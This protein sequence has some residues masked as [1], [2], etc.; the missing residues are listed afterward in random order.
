VLYRHLLLAGLLSSSLA[1]CSRTLPRDPTMAALY[2]DLERQVTVA[3]TAGWSVDRLE[4]EAALPAALDSVCR[5]DPP[6]RLS[7]LEWLD[8]EIHRRGGPVDVA[9]RARGRRLSRVA[10]LIELTRIRM[11]LAH[12]DAAAPVDC[13]FWL[14]VEEPFRGRQISD[15]RWQLTIAGGGKAIA[16][17]QGGRADLSFGGGGRVLVG[18]AFGSRAAVLGGFELGASASFPKDAA[19]QRG[20]L[21]IGLDLVTPLV[22]R[23]TLTNAF[24]EVEAG[25]L[26]H[27]TEAAPSELAHGIHIGV[28]IGARALRTRFFFPGVALGASYERTFGEE[29]DLTMVKLGARVSFDANL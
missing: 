4:V 25:W 19:G 12:A 8:E 6:A 5:V 16:I 20:A 2:R 7:L 27:A 28:S 11:V 3:A 24:I 14:E 1:A 10:D 15:D 17:R 9:W 22:Y 21:E 13:P 29:D 26:G 23:H 18:R